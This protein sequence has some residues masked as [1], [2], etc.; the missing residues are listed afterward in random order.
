M[1]FEPGK[2]KYEA[3]AKDQCRHFVENVRGALD[4]NTKNG[5]RFLFGGGHSAL[6]VLF[7]HVL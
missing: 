4:V 5:I 7:P 1:E 2:V 3:E 6:Q